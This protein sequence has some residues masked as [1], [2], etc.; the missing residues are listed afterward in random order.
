MKKRK[1]KLICIF[2]LIFA[3]SFSINSKYKINYSDSSSGKLDI[4]IATKS[5]MLKAGVAQSYVNKILEF[6]NIT[7]RINNIHEL[8]RISGIGEKTCVKLEK[9]FIVREI[10][11]YKEL[12]IN[13]AS[14][15]ILKYYGFNK[16]QIRLIRNYLDKNK[17]I[18]DNRVTR[19][20]FTGKQYKKYKDIIRYD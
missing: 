6:R 11:Q 18:L 5:Q 17:F 8:S 10:P 15:K 1:S 4:N 13:I 16:K 7:G 14:N 2:F 12:H 20:I 9:Y 3:L 19:K